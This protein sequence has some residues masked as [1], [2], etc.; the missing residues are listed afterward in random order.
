EG[1]G[2]GP[3]RRVPGQDLFFSN[4]VGSSPRDYFLYRVEADD[5][6]NYLGESPS[7]GDFDMTTIV[8]FLGEPVSHLITHEGHQL[9]IL[10]ADCDSQVNDNSCFGQD[11]NLGTLP[12]TDARYVGFSQETNGTL[13]AL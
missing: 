9:R 13:F 1:F 11:G 4:S 8:G 2:G 3:V 12:G 7:H 6:V 10:T 5:S